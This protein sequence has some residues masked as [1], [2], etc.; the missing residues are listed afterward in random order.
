[1]KGERLGFK[2]LGIVDLETGEILEER[3]LFIGKRKTE[4]DR[5]YVKVFIAF[6]EDIVSDEEV[7]G[8][9]IRLLLYMLKSLDYDSLTLTVIPRKAIEELEIQKDTYHRWVN[10]LIAK[11]ILEKVDRYTYRL[12]PYTFI[13]GSTKRAKEKEKL[14]EEKLKEEN[15]DLGLDIDF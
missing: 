9:A 3:V 2:R 10:T 5:G 13:K 12:K 8:K 4:I 1:M 6:L 7:V 15:L 11:G 14:K